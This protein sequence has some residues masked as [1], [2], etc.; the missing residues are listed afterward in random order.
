M[1]RIGNDLVVDSADGVMLGD[2]NSGA[3]VIQ[4]VVFSEVRNEAGRR[5]IGVKQM[6]AQ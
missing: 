2:T 5:P 4:D 1:S 3:E 6:K